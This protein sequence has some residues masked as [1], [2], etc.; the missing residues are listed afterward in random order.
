MPETSPT[1]LVYDVADLQAAGVCSP[2][3]FYRDLAAGR[4][5][6]LKQGKRTIVT[7]AELER[8]LNALPVAR[9]RRAA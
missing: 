4:I 6:A 9:S 8:Y 7:A 2:S 1:K 5:H 3:A